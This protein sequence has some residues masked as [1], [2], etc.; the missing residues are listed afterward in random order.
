MFTALPM[1]KARVSEMVR[2]KMSGRKRKQ[3]IRSRVSLHVV[4]VFIDGAYTH[5]WINGIVANLWTTVIPDMLMLR[6]SNPINALITQDVPRYFSQ[7]TFEQLAKK[8]CF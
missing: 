4:A 3:Q 2:W 5:G 1:K 8:R 6:L 7:V